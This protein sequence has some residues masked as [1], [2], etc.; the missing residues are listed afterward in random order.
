MPAS[1][2]DKYT[3]L[4][5]LNATPTP[6]ATI[7]LVVAGATKRCWLTEVNWGSKTATALAGAKLSVGRPTTS[8]T[9]GA[10]ITPQPIDPGAPAA[11]FTA[12]SGTTVWSAEPTQPGVYLYQAALNAVASEIWTPPEPI[13]INV[14]TRLAVRVEAD[15]STTKV[16]W[17]VTL[18]IQE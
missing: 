6:P 7:V 10:A 1:P 14:S 8:G 9:G 11:I 2:G 15:S 17:V 4:G 3:V 5:E 18:T 13:L 12:L 16:Q